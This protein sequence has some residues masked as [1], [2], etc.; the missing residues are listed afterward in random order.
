M[1]TTFAIREFVVAGGL[2]KWTDL[3]WSVPA[4]PQLRGAGVLSLI[5]DCAAAH[6]CVLAN[7]ARIRGGIC[8]AP[9]VSLTLWFRFPPPVSSRLAN[10]ELPIFFPPLCCKQPRAGTPQRLCSWQ[11]GVVPIL[12]PAA[13]TWARRP[14][15]HP[16][17]ITPSHYHRL[18]H[19]SNHPV[20]WSEQVTFR[21]LLFTRCSSAGFPVDW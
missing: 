2:M 15:S 16:H 6:N 21:I 11:H 8:H 13:Q 20:L 5:S 3:P 1:P 17:T 4:Q 18:W 12:S 14:P 19:A 9:A 7:C 10:Q